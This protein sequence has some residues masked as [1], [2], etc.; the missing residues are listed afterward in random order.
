SV[1]S[2]LQSYGRYFIFHSVFGYSCLLIGMG[3]I[4]S[5]SIRHSGVFSKQAAVILFGT[6]VP[7]IINTLYI[8]HVIN[9][10]ALTLPLML[11]F[12]IVSV[13]YAI[14]KLGLLDIRPVALRLI[15]DHITEAFLVTDDENKIIEYNKALLS[16]LDNEPKS[17]I[18]TRLDDV[19]SHLRISGYT[20]NEISLAISKAVEGKHPVI[21]S[22]HLDLSAAEHYDIDITPIFSRDV[23]IGNIIRFKNVTDYIHNMNTIKE[24]QKLLEINLNEI[25]KDKLDLLEKTS[26]TEHLAQTDELTDMFNYRTFTRYFEAMTAQATREDTRLQL[27][28]I[29]IDNFKL[30]NDT[31][32]HAVGDIVLKRVAGKIKSS[33][34]MND[35]AA[36]YGGDEFVVLFNGKDLQ[37]SYKI[38]EM[39]RLSVSAEQFREMDMTITVSMGLHEHIKDTDRNETFQK[40][41]KALYEAKHTGKNRTVIL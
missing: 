27:A 2:S 32:G 35:I 5:F 1:V 41:D 28:I 21:L 20:P 22:D 33:A 12:F 18:N 4:M 16:K 7:V 26:I 36:R 29:D 17:I 38:L 9:V 6:S 10:D 13:T 23:Y 34:G 30:I 19:T 40:A 31:Y 15:V 24:Y 8:L 39:I 3:F 25:N 37:E 14:F 11:L